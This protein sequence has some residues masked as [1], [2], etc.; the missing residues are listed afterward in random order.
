MCVRIC[1][2]V[3]CVCGTYMRACMCVHVCVFV[4]CPGKVKELVLLWEF[5]CMV[6]G[7]GDGKSRC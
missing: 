2:Y 7:G 3:G 1:V 4:E 5:R 6:S